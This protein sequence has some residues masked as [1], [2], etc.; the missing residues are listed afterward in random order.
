M[1]QN[2]AGIQRATLDGAAILAAPLTATAHC[3][4][5]STETQ[6]EKRESRWMQL[7]QC[8]IGMWLLR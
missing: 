6:T 2:H 4:L 1:V 3:T 7:L 5:V 8:V